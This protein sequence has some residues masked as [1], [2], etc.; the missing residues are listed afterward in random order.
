MKRIVSALLS[1]TLILSLGVPALAAR[2]FTDVPR[3]HVFHAA[4]QDCVEKGLLGG[5]D[6]G[7]F[8][9][10]STVTRAQFVVML[11]RLFYPGEA[12]SGEHD[13]WKYVGWFAPSC[14]VLKEHGSMVYGDQYWTDPS[15]MNQNI[16]R[17]DMAQFLNLTLKSAGYWASESDKAA[18][19]GRITDYDEVGENYAEA[20]KT[21]FALGIITGYADG[22]FAGRTSMTR[23]A[24]A[25]ILGRTAQCIAQ[26]PGE[27][28]PLGRTEPQQPAEQPSQEPVQQPAQANITEEYALEVLA[29]LKER[30]PE[31]TDFSG[32][33][34]DGNGSDVRAAT[35]PYERSRDPSTHT[36]N[37]LGCG[38][39][40]T[41]ISD[42][43]YG[44][45]GYPTRKADMADARPG[46]VMVVTDKNGRLVHV[47]LITARST[48]S[49]KGEVTMYITEAATD[50]SGVYHLH[51]DRSYTWREG[52]TYG[53]DIYTRYPA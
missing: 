1:L 51:W 45:T 43:I 47:A 37:T 40:A 2:E 12:E 41:L 27:L 52:G 44:Q 38:G 11:A 3:D 17:R 30:Y 50:S 15:V 9:P 5:Y 46:D 42:A 22:G 8:R 13:A 31:N 14:A 33:Y 6:D 35:H 49:A 25:A 28:A 32:G 24:A 23:G 19:Q 34:P 53:Y 4:I 29:G 20:V 48:V 26:G 16:T 18:A 21:V 39:W 7:T 36:S 10:A